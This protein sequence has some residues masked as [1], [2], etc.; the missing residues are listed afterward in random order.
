[1]RASFL[2]S[3]RYL[4]DVSVV[5]V[6]KL[7]VEQQ[8]LTYSMHK[9]SHV[10]SLEY[11]QLMTKIEKMNVLKHFPSIIDEHYAVCFML[12]LFSA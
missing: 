5:E 6:K 3:S 7:F 10:N 4:Q 8:G 9:Y 11:D 12:E 1:M 2:F